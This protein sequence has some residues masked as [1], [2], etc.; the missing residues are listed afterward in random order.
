MKKKQIAKIRDF[1]RFYTNFIGLLDKYVLDSNYTLPEARVMFEIYRHKEITAKRITELLGV[2]KGYLSHMLVKFE[3]AGLITKKVDNADG[4]MQILSFTEKGEKVFLSLN[5]AS[6]SQLKVLLANLT[7]AETSE[8]T[9]HMD[10]IK[11]IL[12]KKEQMNNVDKK[13][14]I[15]SEMKP[16][17]LG[18]IMYRQSKL[19]SKEYNY[20]VSFD[21][22]VG[23]SLGEFCQQYDPQLD[24]LWI[25]ETETRIVGSILVMHREDNE[26]QLRYFY[27]E[28]DYRGLGLGNQLLRL[29][30]DFAKERDYRKIYL[31]TENEL[32]VALHLYGKFGFQF[33]E[34][35]VSTHFGKSVVELRLD[36][37]LKDEVVETQSCPG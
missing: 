24:R 16:G 37:M 28:S 17:D 19:Y 18:Y 14:G 34:K 32:D 1:N 10:T 5:E 2:D 27:L 36:L 26:A 23:A 4:R 33:A 8:L 7:E 29:A 13:I 22:Y 31:W 12:S 6:E 35:K 21:T 15:R 11:N 25:C 20:G 9:G 30:I 3:K